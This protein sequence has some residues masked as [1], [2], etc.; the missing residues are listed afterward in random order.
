MKFVMK[1]IIVVSMLAIFSSVVIAA[2]ASKEFIE[3]KELAKLCDALNM[4]KLDRGRWPTTDEG[5]KV[6]AFPRL[7]DNGESDGR[8]YL[9]YIPNDPWGNEYV[10]KHSKK[11]GLELHS[12]GPD[13]TIG[14]NDDLGP[15]VCEILYSKP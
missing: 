9:S 4:F 15:D 6:L 3:N 12:I 13:N 11:I 10:Y 5:L 1:K 7:N 14:T 2:G 8:T